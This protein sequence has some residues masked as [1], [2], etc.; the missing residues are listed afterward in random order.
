MQYNPCTD[1]TTNF[2]KATCLLY[3]V[4]EQVVQGETTRLWIPLISLPSMDAEVSILHFHK[5]C[6]FANTQGGNHLQC[7]SLILCFV[8]EELLQ[9]AYILGEFS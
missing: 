3:I 8:M 1:V 5:G 7:S 2:A 9:F 6:F 4:V